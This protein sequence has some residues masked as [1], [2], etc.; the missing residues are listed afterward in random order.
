[1]LIHVWFVCGCFCEFIVIAVK[2]QQG[3]SKLRDSYGTAGKA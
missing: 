3:K 1:M 2:T